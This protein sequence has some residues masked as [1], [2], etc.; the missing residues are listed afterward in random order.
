MT[1]ASIP[2]IM[3]GIKERLDT[4]LELNTYDHS[5]EQITAPAAFVTVPPIS[6]YRTAM[7][8]GTYEIRPTVVVLVSAS[9]GEDGQ[10]DL[11]E[12]MTPFGDK[13]I[14][15]AIEGDR[16]LGG[17]VNDC[18]VESFE[19]LGMEPVGQIEYIGGVFT[20]RVL[21]RGGSE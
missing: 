2:E 8:R 13:S 17:R 18:V 5:P 7:K 1:E 4:I 3:L 9:S 6:N 12:Y 11:A 15:Q 21:A 10:Y 16:T 19:P 14:V 20:L